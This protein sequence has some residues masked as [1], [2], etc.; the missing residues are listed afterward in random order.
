MKKLIV[1][2]LMASML[3]V[4]AMAQDVSVYLNNKRMVFDQ[5]PI[6]ENGRTLVPLRSIFEGLGAEVKWNPDLQEIKA[7]RKTKEIELNIGYNYAKL[8]TPENRSMAS[9]KYI[10][11]DVPAKIENGRT[12][13]P[14]RFI[15]ESLDA[16]VKWN[17][18]E[19]R[20]DINLDISKSYD[21]IEYL[22]NDLFKIMVDGKYGIINKDGEK[23]LEC[24]YDSMY[25]QGRTLTKS[26]LEDSNESDLISVSKNDKYGYLNKNWE[27]VIPCSYDSIESFNKEG[28]AKA[29]LNGKWGTIDKTGKEVIPFIY[30][31]I[32]SFNEEG[33][34]YVR[35]D[36][37]YGLIDK[38]GK[39]VYS[40]ICDKIPYYEGGIWKINVNGEMGIVLDNEGTTLYLNYDYVSIFSDE[41]LR[42]AKDGKYEEFVVA[43]SI[44]TKYVDGKWSFIN[45]IGEVVLSCDCDYVEDFHEGLAAIERDEKWGYINKQGKEVI[46][47]IYEEV[48][49]FNKGIAR[50]K[51]DDKWGY[52]D[53]QGKEVVPFE[54]SFHTIGP[55]M[56]D[57]II[58]CDS[59][60]LYHAYKDNKEGCFNEQGQVVIPFVYDNI[61]D[62]YDDNLIEV[63]KDKKKGLVD[64]T[65]KEVLPCIYD[66]ITLLG[67]N[68]IKVA[69]DGEFTGYNDGVLNVISYTNSKWGLVDRSG[70]ELIPCVHDNILLI[71]DDLIK[72]ANGGDFIGDE[73]DMGNNKWGLINLE[74]KEIIPC[75]YEEI[76]SFNEGLL[77]VKKDDKWGYINQEGQEVVPFIY[78]DTNSFVDGIAKV[79]KDG[80]YGYIDKEGKE[81]IP[82]IYTK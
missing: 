26:V 49:E 16:E 73:F 68:F 12:L 1:G 5:N 46:P 41:L 23:I 63:M 69:K 22:G 39:E 54:Y 38:D 78:E 21:N 60:V 10:Q 28:V 71:G 2:S 75:V 44:Q 56:A 36:S 25:M 17:E 48:R 35:L 3:V 8:W 34:A 59:V 30:D 53:K 72:V 67:D 27:E 77:N 79:K 45:K 82:F 50:V 74:G 18:D 29:R 37:K 43:A 31:D 80:K 42:I 14:L 70:K 32:G 62:I 40:C 15:A 33:T 4:P 6:I 81:I 61:Q 58:D 20:I 66:K 52:I 57:D 65:G 47:C 76:G 64:I 7:K 11:L 24:I 9:P 55:A 51:K 19:Y 13:V